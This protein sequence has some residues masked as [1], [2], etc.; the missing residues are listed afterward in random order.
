M[1]LKTILSA[2]GKLLLVSMFS[3]A[4]YSLNAQT[5]THNSPESQHATEVKGDSHVVLKSIFPEE[6]DST[7]VA[8]NVLLKNKKRVETLNKE[9]NK[10]IKAEL[11]KEELMYPAIELYGEDSW[12]TNSINPF[13]GSKAVE[14]PDTFSID[15]SQ[16]SHPMG[17]VCRINSRYGYRRRFRRMHYGIDL[18]LAVGDTVRAAFDGK[19]RLTDY[20]RRGYGNYVVMRHPNG[21]ETLYG[22]LSKFLVKP[23]QIVK[24]GDPI[25]L[26]GNTGR[27]TGPH[28]HF[29]T[30][31][32]GVAINPE[33]IIDFVE[34]IPLKEQY[35]FL[36]HKMGVGKTTVTSGKRTPRVAA[37]GDAIKTH[38]IRRGDS[39]SKIASKYGV[40]INQLCKL[41]GI[42]RR[43]TLRVGRTL[44]VS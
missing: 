43:T 23:D 29:E 9:I 31:F 18:K 44:R 21:L 13:A 12:N 2:S 30:R 24:A 3:A 42:S 22:H 11:S 38:K 16:F 15:C 26:G 36:R 27:S 25:A 34:G 1:A 4:F 20:E 5:V 7:L 28:L 19:V 33:K 6:S 41:N 37:E 40:S 17:E 32:M 8:D 35:V 39:L 10:S 14:I